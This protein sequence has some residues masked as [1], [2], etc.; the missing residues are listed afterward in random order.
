MGSGHSPNRSVKINLAPVRFSEDEI[1]VG[2]LEYDG[3]DEYAAL[4]AEHQETHA[5]RFDSRQGSITNVSIADG[6]EPLGKTE[7]VRV[8]GHLLLLGKAV[9]QSILSW[10][11]GH[12]KILKRSKPLMFWGGAEESRLL[13]RA[14]LDSAPNGR[15]PQPSLGSAVDI[16]V[17]YMF[18]TR[19][20]LPPGNARPYLGLAVDVRTS[21]VIDL[22]VADLMDRGLGVVGKYVCKRQNGNDDLLHPKLAT[23]G[24]VSSVEGNRLLLTDSGGVDE[25][26]ARDALLEPRQENLEEIVENLYGATQGKRILKRLKELRGP[27]GTAPGKLSRIEQT[28]EGLRNHHRVTLNGGEVAANFED[29][30]A[31]GSPLFPATIRTNRPVYLFGAQ[32][33][34]TGNH[35]DGGVQRFGP[36]KYMQHTKNEPLIAVVCEASMRG[37]VE[38]FAESLRSG[39]AEEAWQEVTRDWSRPKSNPYPGGLLEKFRLRRVR[40]EFEEVDGATAAEYR[41]A[42]ERLLERLPRAPD[43]AL[44]QTREEFK[45]LRGNQDPYLVSKAAFMGAGVPVQAIGDDKIDASDDQLPYIL[46]S[47]GLASY[48]KLDGKPWVLSTRDPSSHELVIGLGYTE[49]SESRLGEKTRYVGI[50]T[51]FLG[52]GRYLLWGLT[53]AVEFENYADALLKSLHATIR[54]VEK[55]GNWQSKD[56]VRLVFH[57]Y[58]PLK[59]VEIDA[60]KELVRDMV[61]DAYRVEYAFLDLSSHH[62]FQLFDTKQEGTGYRSEQGRWKK[63]GKGVPQRGFCVQLDKGRALLHLIGPGNLKTEEQGAPQPLLIQ[64]HPSSDLDDLTYLVRQIYHF[65][66]LSWRNF[67]P[68]TEPVTILYSRLIAKVL[69]NLRSVEGWDSRVISVGPLRNNMWFL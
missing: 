18:D 65:T 22:S 8:D 5:F 3:E 51:V 42:I 67:Y 66:H 15:G 49:V 37:R 64:V 26:D 24:M 63:K 16:A 9:Q 30:L 56:Q 59:H 34:Q 32:G 19:L 60:I 62:E 55:E 17:R 10:L 57:V 29:L 58:K 46:N 25:I 54:H 36:Y 28:L 43:L 38:Q 13:R 45:R 68:A 33:R 48:A 2:R 21:N 53:R 7:R 44:V 47:V 20:I 14:I 40:Y 52:D 41:E 39:F 27:Y 61:R 69:G 23:I 31:N 4:R 50:T 11:S 35:P 12:R 1:R 6:V